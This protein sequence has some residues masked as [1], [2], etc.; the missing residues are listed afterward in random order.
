MAR[1]KTIDSVGARTTKTKVEALS[2]SATDGTAYVNE[3][4][5]RTATREKS[6]PVIPIISDADD[7]LAAHLYA[8]CVQFLQGLYFQALDSGV[9][10]SGVKPWVI[11]EE[12]GRLYLWGEGFGSGRL[13]KILEDANE[14][15]EN[16]LEILAGIGLL[17][18]RSK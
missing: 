10:H 7:C 9:S 4:I 17:L 18:I 5:N 13:T 8:S 16:I 6:E 14:L 2:G 1:I 3:W 11:R 12:L 15:R